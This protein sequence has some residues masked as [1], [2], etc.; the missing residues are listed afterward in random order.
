[1]TTVPIT[2]ED[3]GPDRTRGLWLRQ[4]TDPDGIGTRPVLTNL[5]VAG[6]KGSSDRART[7]LRVAMAAL[8]ILALTAAI[9]SYQAQYVMI[10]AY[11]GVKI[12]AALQAGIPDAAAL[13]FASLGI[14]LALTGKRAIRARVLNVAA[15]GTSIVMNLLAAS[16]G[17][18]ALAVWVLAPVAYA[19]TSDTLIGVLRSWTLARQREMN[20][21]L[22][23]DDTTLL[24]VIGKAVLYSARFVVAPRSTAKGARLALLNATP[25]PE[26]EAPRPVL[27]PLPIIGASLPVPPKPRAIT[28]PAPKSPRPRKTTTTRTPTSG[29]QDALIKLATG[30]HGLASLPVDQ[31]SRLATRLAPE[32][33]IH[34][35]TARRVLV[36]HA[37]AL[38]NGGAK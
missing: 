17:W 35:A 23:D 29:K 37:R 2:A 28:P 14:A 11:K 36:N 1:V 22:A 38:Q 6:R 3:R 9:V 32:V 33:G 18:K 26:P 31:V 8:G 30:S 10:Y 12:I 20:A 25:L 4:F 19:V 15:V 13:V 7:W 24:A 27:T 16:A 34:P 5:K 21:D